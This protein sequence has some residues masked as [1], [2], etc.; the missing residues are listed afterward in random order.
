MK[1]LL[2]TDQEMI[3]LK[4]S[5]VN[6]RS[7]HELMAQDAMVNH[8]KSLSIDSRLSA[9]DMSVVTDIATFT[10]RGEPHKLMEFA[11]IYCN[12]HYPD[13]YPI[14]SEQNFEFLMDY[15]GQHELSITQDDLQQYETFKKVLDSLIDKYNHAG[16]LNYWEVRKLG[17]AYIDKALNEMND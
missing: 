11:S 14:Y 12:S 13:D 8:I 6:H 16:K 9:K 7:I 17:W 5:A 3:T 2:N 1:N 4:V 15:V 10:V